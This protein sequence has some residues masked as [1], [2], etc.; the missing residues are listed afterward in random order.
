MIVGCLV[1]PAGASAQ[2]PLGV[3]VLHGKQGT[4]TGNQGLNVIAANLQ[5]AGHKVVQPA[6]P[7]GRGGWE[8][9]NVTVEEVLAMLDGQAVQLRAQG[10]GR[11]VVIGH[12]LGAAVGLAYAVERGNLAGLVMLAPGHN[13]A[14]LYRSNDR[15][16]G[17]VD[18]TRKLVEEGKGNERVNGADNNQGS[19]ITMSV[20]AAVY[21]SWQ[22]PNGIASMPVAAPR[23]PA[24]T[25]LLMVV[26]EKDVIHGRAEGQLYRPA[27]KSPYSK[28]VTNGASHAETPMAATKVVTDWVNLLPR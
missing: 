1:V 22:N 28:Y 7:W 16:R 21:Y 19:N 9:I 2:A 5:S 14:G 8:S 17:D 18:R 26:G 13:P 4:P 3:I 20:R 25:P 6:M 10:A 12:S 23:L 15:I 11:I 27:A 24:S